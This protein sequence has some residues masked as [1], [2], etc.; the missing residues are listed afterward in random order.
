MYIWGKFKKFVITHCFRVLFIKVH[1]LEVPGEIFKLKMPWSHP[2]KAY[3]FWG[4]L[5]VSS[6][7]SYPPFM[8]PSPGELQRFQTNGRI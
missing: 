8:E 7:S 5:P 1:T 4:G 2:I 3:T 6:I